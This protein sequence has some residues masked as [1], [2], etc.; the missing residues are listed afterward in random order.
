MTSVL[1]REVKLMNALSR[2]GKTVLHIDCNGFYGGHQASLTWR[3]LLE[4]LSSKPATDDPESVFWQ[5]YS[6]THVE[7]YQEFDAVNEDTDPNLVSSQPSHETDQEQ[8]KSDNNAWASVLGSLKQNSD[9]VPILQLCF[10]KDIVDFMDGKGDLSIADAETRARVKILVETLVDWNGYVDLAPKLLYSRGDIVESL[11]A[12]GVGR[13]LEFRAI[14]R[15]QMLWDSNFQVV[16]GS[17]EDV[18][19]DKSVSLP[20]KRRLMKF[21]TSATETNEESEENLGE[22]IFG[23]HDAQDLGGEEETHL[24]LTETPLLEQSSIPFQDYLKQQKFSDKLVSVILHAIT[25][26]LNEDKTSNTS[27]RAGI[28]QVKR[29]LSSI[30]RY[31]KTPFLVDPYGTGC[32]LAQAFCRWVSKASSAVH[33]GIYVLKAKM[34]AVHFGNERDSIQVESEDGTK[35]STS[36]L[37]MAP[38]YTRLSTDQTISLETESIARA[39]IKCKNP[40]QDGVDYALTVFPPESLGGSDGALCI[41]QPAGRKDSGYVLYLM[42]ESR[43]SPREALEP[44]VRL[45][46]GKQGTAVAAYYKQTIPKSE[47]TWIKE[48]VAVCSTLGKDMTRLVAMEDVVSETRQMFEK[49]CP[50]SEFLPFNAALEEW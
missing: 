14:E 37:I 33:G 7:V 46:A 34:K 30:G 39:V 38:E 9:I 49:I 35:I 12:S 20:D 13:Y 4:R 40:V 17:K 41:Q 6:D 8:P 16:P 45:L 5:S 44:I 26:L 31:G 25:M 32:E 29:Y 43:S 48:R 23:V 3:E 24:L 19:A 18:F 2:A 10:T 47:T 11:I 50:E 42:S 28:S 21:L 36:W 27:T 1:V 22:P 15:I